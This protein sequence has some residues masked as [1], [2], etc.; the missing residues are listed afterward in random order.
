MEEK[1]IIRR[2]NRLKKHF[3]NVSNVLLYGYK[4]LSDAAKIT[5]QVIEGFDWENKETG[6]SK[7]F[8]FPAI[9]AIARIRNSAKRTIFRHIQELEKVGL[10]SRVR[11]R[12][13]PSIL[14]IEEVSDEEA[15]NYLNRY[16]DKQTP[17]KSKEQE[18]VKSRNAKNGTSGE[19]REMPKMALAY[20]KENEMK[21]NEMNVNENLQ[22]SERTESGKK[23]GGMQGLSD[24]MKRFDPVKKH[25]YPKPKI[26]KKA[27]AR[28]TPDEKAKRDYFANEIATELNDEKSLGCYRTIADKVPQQVIFEI[29]SSVKET[30][31]EGKIKKSRGALFVD[32]IKNY[33]DKKHINLQFATP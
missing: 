17:V 5:Y 4:K 11:Q 27:A 22:N 31:K 3:V 2:R 33:C 14:Y 13:K 7:G 12:N 29:L 10:L 1:I 6:D 16:V 20:M 30:W 19:A 26:P 32:L 8:V 28:L 15:N 24:I 9:E 23:R 25:P 18:H 21:E